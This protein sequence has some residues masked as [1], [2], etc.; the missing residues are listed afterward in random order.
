MATPPGLARGSGA[1]DRRPTVFIV[2]VPPRTLNGFVVHGSKAPGVRASAEL[3]SP[4]TQRRLVIQTATWLRFDRSS[5]VRMC[6][7]WFCAVRSE[8]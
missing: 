6:W 8:R 2:S 3:L 7:T 4:R 1:G 5:L